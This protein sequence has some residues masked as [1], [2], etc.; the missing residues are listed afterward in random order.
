MLPLLIT[1]GGG[2]KMPVTGFD[3]PPPIYDHTPSIPVYEHVLS[4]EEVTKTCTPFL[5]PLPPGQSGLG[6]NLH[7]YVD[8]KEFCIIYRVANY[9]VKR[10]EEGHCNG[11]ARDH[12]NAEQVAKQE[13]ELELRK[14]EAY[15]KGKQNA[16]IAQAA[17]VKKDLIREA[18]IATPKRTLPQTP[19]HLNTTSRFLP[20]P[21]NAPTSDLKQVL[22]IAKENRR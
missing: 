20:W 6:C 13:A 16:V 10:H 4:L 19:L 2:N 8:G 21:D 1:Q 17:E 11:W 5:P 22:G 9:R 3:L 18:I 12:P 7:R 14:K 15:L